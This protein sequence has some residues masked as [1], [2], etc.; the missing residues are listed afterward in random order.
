MNSYYSEDHKI[1]PFEEFD[2]TGF[3]DDLTEENKI[4]TIAKHFRCIM[5]TLG[6]DL[7]DDSLKDTPERVSRMYVK[8]I[9][10]GLNPKNFPK[11]TVFKKPNNIG[12]SQTIFVKNVTVKSFCEHHFVPMMGTACIAYIPK[13]HIIGLSKINR[14]VNYFARRPQ[15]QERLTAQI[16]DSLTEILQTEDV[17]V[18]LTLQHSCISTRG[19]NDESSQAVTNTLRGKFLDDPIQQQSFFEVKS[20]N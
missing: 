12:T 18:S 3:V 8:E 17:A 7:E 10:A 6:L 5:E 13:E 15:L 2:E 1:T 19:V 20:R 16:A 4:T 11:I 9:F 14:I